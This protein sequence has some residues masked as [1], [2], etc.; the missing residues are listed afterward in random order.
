[1][2][3]DTIIVPKGIYLVACLTFIKGTVQWIRAK[4]EA[5]K[6]VGDIQHETLYNSTIPYLNCFR[7]MTNLGAWSHYVKI[8]PYQVD[9]YSEIGVLFMIDL[10]KYPKA[11]D[12]LSSEAEI[13]ENYDVIEIKKNLLNPSIIGVRIPCEECGEK[14]GCDCTLA[15][16]VEKTIEDFQVDIDENGKTVIRV[17]INMEDFSNEEVK[18]LENDIKSEF[19][20]E[21]VEIIFENVTSKVCPEIEKTS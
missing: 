15:R 4:K 2:Q 7:L 18:E 21:C 6:K 3:K 10:D 16:Q 19:E 17:K 1:M 12:L 5:N 9:C 11:Y 8:G 13:G 14:D 20:D